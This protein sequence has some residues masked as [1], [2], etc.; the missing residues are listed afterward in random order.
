[1]QLPGNLDWNS[2]PQHPELLGAPVAAALAGF[3]RAAEVYV[4][5][6]DPDLSDTEH[7]CATYGVEMDE[8]ANCVVVAGKREGERRIAACVILATTRA[9]V[10]GV[11]RR[12]IDVRK[13]SFLPVDEA[14]EITGMQYGGITPIGLPAAWPVLV[15]Q[16]VIDAGVVVIGSGI[17]GSKL[18]VPGAAL[19]ELPGAEVVA[20][21]AR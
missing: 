7:F 13:S 1:M 2:A 14:V 8:S 20:G 5:A 9:D 4:A 12:R 21:L 17:R 11:V 16:A 3:P 6:I 18:A 10:N 15:D 19:A